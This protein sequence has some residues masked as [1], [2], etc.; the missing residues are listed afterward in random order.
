MRTRLSNEI[1]SIEVDTLGAEPASIKDAGGS[2]LCLMP[3]GR[4]SGTGWKTML[5]SFGAII[6]RDLA[7]AALTIEPRDG[8][9]LFEA[10]YTIAVSP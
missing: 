9:G 1:L 10:A 3:L 8:N 7:S 5:F 6:L 2:G 4:L